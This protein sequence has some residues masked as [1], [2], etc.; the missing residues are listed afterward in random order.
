MEFKSIKDINESNLAEAKVFMLGLM[1]LPELCFA[2]VKYDGVE[3]TAL[4]ETKLS[5]A[6]SEGPV[7]IPEGV[8]ETLEVVDAS[9]ET[10]IKNLANVMVD[11]NVP[12][13]AATQT[14][15]TVL[16]VCDIIPPADPDNEYM[17]LMFSTIK[18]HD[19]GLMYM[20]Q[21]MASA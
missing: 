11:Y 21:T 2:T 8:L 4:T 1:S 12:A 10:R 16:V 19:N 18:N 17:E 15:Q 7:E 13:G 9:V 6:E 3:Y 5:N 20:L 14:L